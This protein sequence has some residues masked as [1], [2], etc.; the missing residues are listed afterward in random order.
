MKP[1]TLRLKRVVCRFQEGRVFGIGNERD[2]G[3]VLSEKLGRSERFVHADLPIDA[4]IFHHRDLLC[5]EFFLRF[6]IQ[7]GG[8]SNESIGLNEDW[9]FKD[10]DFELVG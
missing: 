10:V 6:T 7:I 3:F 9:K 1:V 4:G 2:G 5:V 8:R